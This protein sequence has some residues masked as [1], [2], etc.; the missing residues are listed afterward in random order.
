MCSA[1]VRDFGIHGGL[2]EHVLNKVNIS[3]NKNTMKGDLSAL[4]P[5]G[6]RFG[7]P[8]MTTRGCT[9]KHF[10]QIAEF[11]YRALKITQEHNKFEKLIEFKKHINQIFKEG[12]R[13]LVGLRKDIVEFSSALD[14]HIPPA[15]DH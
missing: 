8:A 11:L 10:E 12:N 13:E 2:Y 3:A 14:F 9:E 7:A 4:K 1:G 5:S 6:M 15:F